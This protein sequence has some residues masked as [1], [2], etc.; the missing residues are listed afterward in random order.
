MCEILILLRALGGTLVGGNYIARR[1]RLQ[2]WKNLAN[3]C[4]LE[5]V[6]AYHSKLI[7]S[8]LEARDGPVTVRIEATTRTQGY[9][10]RVL[11]TFPRPPG[12]R[13]QPAG[14]RA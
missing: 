4:G 6:K 12:L 9:I 10:L 1:E 14:R 7:Y 8:R 5:V 3:S 13:E 11:A 2:A